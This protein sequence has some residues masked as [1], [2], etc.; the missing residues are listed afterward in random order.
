MKF[1]KIIIAI[2]FFANMTMLI[3]GQENSRENLISYPVHGNCIELRPCPIGIKILNPDTKNYIMIDDLNVEGNSMSWSPDY[4]FFSYATRRGDL[5]IFDVEKLKNIFSIPASNWIWS[6]DS[7]SVA[8]VVSTAEGLESHL[9]MLNIQDLQLE[10]IT[11]NRKVDLYISWSPDNQFLAYS[12]QPEARYPHSIDGRDTL[13]IYDTRSKEH[14]QIVKPEMTIHGPVLWSPESRSFI[15]TASTSDNI[16][17]QNIFL[18]S[19]NSNSLKELPHEY[20]KNWLPEW[21]TDGQHIAFLSGDEVLDRVMIF[22]IATNQ[23]E[24][25]VHI[26]EGSIVSVSWILDNK[27][28]LY[29]TT[30]RQPQFNIID[31][32]TGE[33]NSIDDVDIRS[34]DISP[35]RKNIVYIAGSIEDSMLC[36]ASLETLQTECLTDE[37]PYFSSNL[38]WGL[39]S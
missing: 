1:T 4:Q 2:I 7:S 25:A 32:S 37:T 10:S 22:E 16:Q 8:I 29:S 19:L 28:I 11:E 39:S 6:P 26:D 20:T 14:T 5:N 12:I 18:Y 21:S 36:L 35:D 24:N 33:I 13:M 15:F 3:I 30:S 17:E 38:Y 34:F 23:L 9:L 27:S 31:V